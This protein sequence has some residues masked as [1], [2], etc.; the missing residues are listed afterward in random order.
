MTECN[1]THPPCRYAISFHMEANYNC[2]DV[3]Q[4]WGKTLELQ[5]RC[6]S[7]WSGCVDAYLLFPVETQQIKAAFETILIMW[8]STRNHV[9][10]WRRVVYLSRKTTRW[11]PHDLALEISCNK[12][13]DYHGEKVFD[14]APR[15][16]SGLKIYPESRVPNKKKGES[17]AKVF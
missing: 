16:V 10:S 1:V 15:Q 17:V 2:H 13:L 9:I 3:A 7:T 4:A 6:T 5:N 12:P 14:S 8:Y 11:T